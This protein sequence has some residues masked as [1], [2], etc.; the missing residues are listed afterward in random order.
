ME[1]NLK[2]E[3]IKNENHFSSKVSDGVRS[4]RMDI[5]H[6]QKNSKPSDL[7]A[8]A[9]DQMFMTA[10]MEDP[11]FVKEQTLIKRRKQ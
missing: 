6:T 1:Y 4:I 8:E 9:I 7:P 3:N 10:L 11:S 2:A 5:S